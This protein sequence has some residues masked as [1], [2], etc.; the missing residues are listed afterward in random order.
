MSQTSKTGRNG[1]YRRLVFEDLVRSGLLADGDVLVMVDRRGVQH[2]SVVRLSREPEVVHGD[3]GPTRLFENCAPSLFD[4]ADAVPAGQIETG[5][6]QR[7]DNPTAAANHVSA[8]EDENGWIAWRTL[9]DGAVLET[10]RW[11][12]RVR[13]NVEHQEQVAISEWIRFRLDRGEDPGE[14]DEQAISKWL[15][16]QS[17]Q[18]GDEL[19]HKGWLHR[20]CRRCGSEHEKISPLKNALDAKHDL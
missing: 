3:N 1:G 15:S 16:G 19:A 11:R 20:W 8:S 13:Q 6:G 18:P 12:L 7:F 17:L 14:H 10:L 9:I 4:A 5:D 2:E